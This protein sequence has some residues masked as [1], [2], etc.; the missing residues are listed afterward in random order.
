MEDNAETGARKM[1]CIQNWGKVKYVLGT[2]QKEDLKDIRTLIVLSCLSVRL[3]TYSLGLASRGIRHQVAGE[4]FVSLS[5]DEHGTGTANMHAGSA[6]LASGGVCLLGDLA[7]YRKD[8]MEGLQSGTA[9]GLVLT[10]SPRLPALRSPSHS[11]S[12]QLWRPGPRPCS[13]RGRS[14]E[15]TRTSSSPSPSSATSGLSAT[16]PRAQRGPSAA[17]ALFWGQR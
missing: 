14:T 5:R 9:H 11:C 4:L 13:S 2:G 12:P 10:A 17:T 7:S 15:R 3:M 16:S 6:L 1:T 8:K